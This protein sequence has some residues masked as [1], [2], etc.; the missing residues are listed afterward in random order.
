MFMLLVF[1]PPSQLNYY[2]SALV[3]ISLMSRIFETQNQFIIRF[4][5]SIAEQLE[6]YF[7]N[8]DHA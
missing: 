5:E 2:K 7:E 6:A 8:P 4:P 1:V 3:V